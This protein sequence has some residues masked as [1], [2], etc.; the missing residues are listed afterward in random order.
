MNEPTETD[1]DIQQLWLKIY[2]RMVRI[3]HFER[4]AFELYTA[5][6]L[7][8]FMHISIGQEATAVGACMALRADDYMTSTHRGHGD[9]IAK[10]VSVEAAMAELYGKATGACRGKGGSMHIADFSKNIMGANG[11]VAAGAPI[12]TGA[13]LSAKKRNSGQVALCF[14]GDGALASGPI[15]ESLNMAVLWQLPVIFLRQNNR[16]AESTPIDDHQG[17]PDVVEWAKGYGASAVRVDGNDVL[18][19]Y[20]AVKTAA[21]RG[22][23]G[24]GPTFIES[25]T[26]RWYGHNI[27]DPGTNRPQEEIDAWK[28]RDPIRLFK[29]VIL[30]RGAADQAILDAIENEEIQ[31]LEAAISAAE[32]DP[33]PEFS[34][35]LEDLYVDPILGSRAIQGVRP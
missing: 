30:E 18:A 17:I 6:K 3:R 4:A 15:H 25:E 19:V 20:D 23:S 31:R 14:F 7:P 27:G 35:A 2:R 5:G 11:I 1:Q 12:A 26:Y 28:K 34:T 13:A 29:E 10:G 22:R 9:T 24:G 21:D 32:S 33:I 8:G 16:Y